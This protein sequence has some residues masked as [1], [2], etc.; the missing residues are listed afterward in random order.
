MKHIRATARLPSSLVWHGMHQIFVRPERFRVSSVTRSSDWRRRADAVRSLPLET[1]LLQRGAKQDPRDKAKWHT[2]RGVLLVTESKFTNWC[3]QIGGGGA[4]DL[5]IHLA[6][7]DFRETVA[8]LEQQFAA[9]LTGLAGVP[10]SADRSSL[11]R[12]QLAPTL[13]T[14]TNQDVTTNIRRNQSLRRIPLYRI[15]LYRIPLYRIPL[16]RIS[17]QPI[18]RTNHSNIGSAQ[19]VR[20][21]HRR[22]NVAMAKQLLNGSN[23]GPVL[24]Q[25]GS[26]RM[27]HVL[28]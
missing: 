2:E 9:S 26:K 21:D 7:I 11:T 17:L 12:R 19:H 5:V 15:P 6:K 18:Q 1:I 23:I 25:V 28:D 16:Y 22:L 4:I 27:L 3:C 13:A 20:V 24:R 8:W 14:L 10:P